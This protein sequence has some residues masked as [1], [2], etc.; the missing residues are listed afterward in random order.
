MGRQ[1]QLEDDVRQLEQGA[2][3]VDQEEPDG[4][5]PDHRRRE[6]RPAEAT[7]GEPDAGQR[8]A[9]EAGDADPTIGP[10]ASS[11]LARVPIVT[12][13]ATTAVST[14]IE[15]IT[16]TPLAR[17]HRNRDSGADRTISSRRSPS[18]EAQPP[19]AVAAASPN[20]STA[21]VK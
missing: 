21:K 2:E 18:S 9:I 6:S 5:Q 20:M 7:D 11:P 1:G 12:N 19:T 15:A 14:A 3:E 13:V 10:T 4:E 16:P 8:S 17:P